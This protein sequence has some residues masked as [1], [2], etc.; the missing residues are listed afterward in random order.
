MKKLIALLLALVMVFGLVACGGEKAPEA[1]PEAAPE[2]QPATEELETTPAAEEIVEATDG[3][4]KS[5]EISADEK[6]AALGIPGA[7]VLQDT[8]VLAGKKIGCSICYKG[9]EWCAAL[10]AGLEALGAY[11]GVENMICDDGDLNDETQTKQIENYIANQVDMIM[12]DPITFDGSSVALNKAVDAGIPIIVY[13]G[14]WAEGAEKAETTVTWDQ[15]ATGTLTGEYF[16]NYI[17]ENCGGK[18]TIVELTNAVSTHCQERFIGLH[19]VFDA[20]T[21]CE[22]T[23]LDKFDSQGN[24]ET[25]ANA[26]S[27]IVQPYDFV[28]S[29]VDNGA[30]GA[31]AALQMV[32]NTDV[33]VLSMGAYGKEPFSL[34]YNQDPNYLACLNVDAWV[35]AQYIFDGAINY[36]SGVENVPQTNIAL[37]MVDSSNV[38]DFWSDFE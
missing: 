21:D 25:A 7:V 4:V 9:D 22:I 27:A 23:I 13:D 3:P 14:A 2:T 16:I 11:Y 33:K 18:A 30:Q 10:A 1:A 26:I 34:L 35:L 37:F 20:A 31:V 6:A 36:F 12:V 17:R 38:T 28:I 8:D 5:D 32:G 24:R 19:E 29:D 15:K